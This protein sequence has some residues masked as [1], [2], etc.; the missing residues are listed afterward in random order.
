MTEQTHWTLDKI[1]AAMTGRGIT[2][3]MMDDMSEEELGAVVVEIIMDG[4][5]DGKS[6]S[7]LPR[8]AEGYIDAD[9]VAIMIWERR[10]EAMEEE[11]YYAKAGN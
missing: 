9:H 6:S 8:D 1:D 10:K 2:F 7:D 3:K 4:G 11:M 5:G